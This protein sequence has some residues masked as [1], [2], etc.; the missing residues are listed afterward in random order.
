M[1]TIME[2]NI[3]TYLV[4]EVIPEADDVV[5]LRLRPLQN[6]I[7][8]YKA[9]QFITIFFQ[10]LGTKK[11][12]PTVSHLLLTSQ[13]LALLFAVL[14]LFLTSSSLKKLGIQSTVRCRM[15]IFILNQKQ[16]L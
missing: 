8:P 4:Q 10:K 5:T 11:A 9:G 1:K 16:V 2:N 12:S 3:I 6:V 7:P 14:A 13:V 15:D